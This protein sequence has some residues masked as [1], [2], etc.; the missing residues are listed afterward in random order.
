[1]TVV[2]VSYC[3]STRNRIQFLHI[4]LR[5]QVATPVGITVVSHSSHSVIYKYD[6]NSNN[7]LLMVAYLVGPESKEL[8]TELVTMLFCVLIDKCSCGRIYI[9]YSKIGIFFQNVNLDSCSLISGMFLLILLEIT[10]LV[11]SI[12]FQD[13]QVPDLMF[14]VGLFLEQT[15][16]HCL[17][18]LPEET[19]YHMSPTRMSFS[20]ILIYM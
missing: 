10:S 14:A 13:Y 15:F 4:T 7:C 20:P 17:Q 2:S 12:L 19:S 6:N 5:S 9:I 8:V 18:S 3:T 11:T 16:P 1:M